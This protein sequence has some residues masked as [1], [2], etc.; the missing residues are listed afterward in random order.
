MV[1]VADQA[2]VRSEAVIEVRLASGAGIDPSPAQP[3]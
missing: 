1:P 3:A 2:A